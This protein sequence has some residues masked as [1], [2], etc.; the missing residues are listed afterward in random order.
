MGEK[1]K[2]QSVF[3]KGDPGKTNAIGIGGIEKTILRGPK[4]QSV[5]AKGAGSVPNDAGGVVAN[6]VQFAIASRQMGEYIAPF[7]E[8]IRSAFLFDRLIE[9]HANF[10]IRAGFVSKIPIAVLANSPIHLETIKAQHIMAAIVMFDQRETPTFDS[11]NIFFNV[12]KHARKRRIQIMISIGI[13]PL[14]GPIRMGG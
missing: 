4:R 9:I 13:L 10:G 6:P 1:I 5:H 12:F 11:T 8:T 3:G 2:P 14:N 7:N